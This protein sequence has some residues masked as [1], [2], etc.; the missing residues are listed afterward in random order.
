M[1]FVTIDL[2][3]VNSGLIDQDSYGRHLTLIGLLG[4]S[5]V[6]RSNVVEAA[7]V[8]VAFVH[9][10]IKFQLAFAMGQVLLAITRVDGSANLEVLQPVKLLD[11]R[12]F[13]LIYKDLILLRLTLV[14]KF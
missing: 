4:H 12:D 10:S 2:A 8:P 6:Q 1:W 9:L 13:D 3:D 7:L 14:V 11:G 5:L